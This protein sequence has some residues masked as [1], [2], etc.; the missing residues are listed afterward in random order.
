[1]AASSGTTKK[2]HFVKMMWLC[3]LLSL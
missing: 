3:F 2:F 1:M